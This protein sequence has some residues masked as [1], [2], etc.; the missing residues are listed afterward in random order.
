MVDSDLNRTG[1]DGPLSKL[2]IKCL[3]LDRVKIKSKRKLYLDECADILMDAG[4]FK[5]TSA[6]ITRLESVVKEL[7][8]FNV[9]TI[10]SIIDLSETS[11]DIIINGISSSVMRAILKSATFKKRKERHKS[12][13]KMIDCE[14]DL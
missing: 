14:I 5:T 1:I 10:E 12:F 2:L 6:Q 3:V 11:E 8:K 13:E 9:T 7:N 4:E